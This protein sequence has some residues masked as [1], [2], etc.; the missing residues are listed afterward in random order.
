MVSAEFFEKVEEML[1]E[2]RGNGQPAGGLQLI[3]C[4]DFFQ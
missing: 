2:V 1:R 3:I 4:G